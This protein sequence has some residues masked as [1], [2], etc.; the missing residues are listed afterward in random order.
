MDHLSI[1]HSVR[2]IIKKKVN[3]L[4]NIY[5]CTNRYGFEATALATYGFDREKLKCFQTYCH[6]KSPTTTLEEL[7][8]LESDIKLDIIA[9]IVIFVLLRI[10][11]FL[12]LRW[13]LKKQR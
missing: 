5:Y 4:K 1:I 10:A 6:F 2:N 7:D 11:A 9:L 12:F 8:M 3:Y 13:K